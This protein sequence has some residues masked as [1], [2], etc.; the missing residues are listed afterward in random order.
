MEEIKISEILRHTDSINSL[1]DSLQNKEMNSKV[2]MKLD[3]PIRNKIMNYVETVRSIQQ[4]TEGE[5]S[6]TMC[7]ESNSLFPCTCSESMHTDPHHGH[8]VTGDLRIIENSKLRKLFS[9]GPNYRENKTINYK[10][11]ERNHFSIKYLCIKYG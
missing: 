4:M 3:S 1:S 10:L 5:I 2:V 6:M 8:V 9:K 11:F 7:S